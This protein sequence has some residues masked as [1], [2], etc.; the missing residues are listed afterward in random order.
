MKTKWPINLVLFLFIFSGNST[1][2]S[3]GNNVYVELGGPGVASINY[4]M[5]FQKKED[6]LGFRA[7]IGGFS[8]DGS[9]YFFVPLGLNYL[10]SKDEKNYFELGAGLTLVSTNGSSDNPKNLNFN[11]NFGHMYFGYRRQPKKGG[12]LFR[13]GIVPI[14]SKDF[15]F[16][17]Y[18]GVSCG[19]KF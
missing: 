7:G 6:G 14:F 2:Q 12:F 18:A 15:F 8:I 11:S 16:P 19:Y 3:Y 9:S 10:I 4:D 1:A 17:F 5:R 13:A